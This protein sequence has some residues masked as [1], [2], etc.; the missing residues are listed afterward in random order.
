MQMEQKSKSKVSLANIMDMYHMFKKL[1]VKIWT[2]FLNLSG[3]DD[4]LA[5][6]K[7]QPV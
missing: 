3:F 6:Q 7:A 4:I 2:T 1:Q 5:N